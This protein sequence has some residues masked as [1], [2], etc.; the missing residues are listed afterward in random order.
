MSCFYGI[1]IHRQL[2]NVS[3]KDG[4]NQYNDG[5]S[6]KS[7]MSMNCSMLVMAKDIPMDYFGINKINMES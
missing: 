6:Q 5:R 2:F 3:G 4:Y 7:F 1:F